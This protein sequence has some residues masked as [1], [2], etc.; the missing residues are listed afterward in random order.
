M[1]YE[2]TNLTITNYNDRCI[3]PYCSLYISING[4]KSYKEINLTEANKLMWELMKKGAE[5]IF[6]PNWYDNSISYCEVRL[7]KCS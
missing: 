7:W 1:K 4:D 6:Y 2:Y 5:R 3:A